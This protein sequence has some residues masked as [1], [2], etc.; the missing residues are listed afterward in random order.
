MSIARDR[1]EEALDVLRPGLDADGFALSIESVEPDGAV[2]VALTATPEACMDCLVPDEMMVSMIEGTMKEK[3][4]GVDRVI[5]KKY[6]FENV[7][8]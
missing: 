1:I 2:N 8:G 7:Q 5:L 4:P 6:N 3:D